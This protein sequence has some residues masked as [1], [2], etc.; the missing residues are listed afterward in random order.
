MIVDWYKGHGYHFLA[1]SDHNILSQGEKWIDVAESR[2]GLEAYQEYLDR[3][4]PRWVEQREVDSKLWARL[5]PLNEFRHRFE[6]PNRFLLI[7][8]EEITDRFGKL[9]VHLNA[10]NLVEFI[11]P[12]GGTSVLE[13]MQNNVDAVLAQRQTTRQPM[14]P[15]VNHPN[16]GWAVTA[17]DIAA[18]KGERFFEVY[19][20]HPAVRNYGDAQHTST[21]RMWDIILTHRLAE[22][23]GEVIYGIAVD[24]AHNY[25][26]DGSDKSNPGRGWVMVRAAHLTP[27][28]IIAAMEVGDFYAS[29][30]VSLEEI[31]W[32]GAQIC[33]KIRG[34][35]GVSYVTQFIG[36][37]EEYDRH[38]EPVLIA[39][40]GQPHP[41]TR[42]YSDD[43]GAI[44]A[45]VKGTSPTY[46]LTGDESYVRAKVISSKL[47]PSQ[48][49]GRVIPEKESQ[50]L[51]EGV[52]ANPYAEGE[53]EV[54]WT[55]PFVPKD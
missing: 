39:T 25:H 48:W 28:G 49:S 4:G 13:V 41:V 55:Q 24:D 36:T 5:K 22:L 27:E 32:D 42:R 50:K 31:R 6:E 1:L 40:D 43:I 16:F 33:L 35:A 3:F 44:L 17:E 26:I 51:R 15:H 10:T 53:V 7:Q 52:K 11:P 54:A 23:G 9:P 30:G 18:L 2:G 47:T 14:F 38:S 21:E 34:E 20:G 37:R 29:T 46:T 8:G 12:Q 19:N 45:E